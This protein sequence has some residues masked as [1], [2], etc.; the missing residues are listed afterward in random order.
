MAG[1]QVDPALLREAAQGINDT[2]SALKSVGISEAADVGRGF[3]GLEL[4]GLQAGSQDVRQAFSGFCERWSWGVRAL[5]RDGNEIA[6]RNAE[7]TWSGVGRD[8][9]EG[10]M[11]STRALA[12]LTG[13][14]Q[15][16]TQS[17]N[18]VFGPPPAQG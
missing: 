10:P 8:V 1:Y 17:E 12:D 15:Q 3:S 7:T 11:G 18:Q 13:N 2:I 6:G 4:T 14:G 5:V 16:L 9:A